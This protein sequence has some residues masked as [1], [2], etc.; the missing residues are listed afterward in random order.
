MRALFLQSARNVLMDLG[1]SWGNLRLWPRFR[2]PGFGDTASRVR[3]QQWWST[4]C[5][6]TRT[7]WS[8][9]CEP[10]WRAARAQLTAARH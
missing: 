9:A 6:P 10:K 1:D 5:G 4:R 7:R 2:D 3:A 8:I